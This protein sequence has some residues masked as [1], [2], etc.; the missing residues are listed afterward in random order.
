[1]EKGLFSGE[2]RDRYLLNKHT[3]VHLS[4]EMLPAALRYQQPASLE[5]RNCKFV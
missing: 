3:Y 1:M 5:N 4:F 2:R